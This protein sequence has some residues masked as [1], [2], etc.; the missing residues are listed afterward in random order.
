MLCKMESQEPA[1]V[2]EDQSS[3]EPQS[4]MKLPDDLPTSLDDRK[5]FSPYAGETE[6]YDG[7]QGNA[8]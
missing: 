3:E 5:S 1:L 8:K 7:W 4:P 2:E 6:M